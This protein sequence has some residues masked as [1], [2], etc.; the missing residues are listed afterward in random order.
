MAESNK[1]IE[2]GNLDHKCRDYR[3][4]V[5]GHFIDKESPLCISEFEVKWGRHSKG[6][7]KKKVAANKTAKT[8]AILISGK[9]KLEFPELGEDAVLAQEGDYVFYDAGV[10]HAWEV[11]EDCLIINIR[12]PSIP[13]D[14]VEK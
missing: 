11:L 7:K 14:Q 13:K 1:K 10:A 2:I 12:W 8:L 9:F 5:A 6:E 3:G 4:W